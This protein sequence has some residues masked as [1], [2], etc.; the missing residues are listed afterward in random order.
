[1]S[2]F[3]GLP[4]PEMPYARPKQPRGTLDVSLDEGEGLRAVRQITSDSRKA[5]TDGGVGNQR[6]QSP[7]SSWNRSLIVRA[8]LGLGILRSSG[9]SWDR[10]VFNRPVRPGGLQFPG[11][12]LTVVPRSSESPRFSSKR[13]SGVLQL[14]KT[15]SQAVLGSWNSSCDR[16]S[17]PCV[18]L[19]SVY[20]R[21]AFVLV[22]EKRVTRYY[23]CPRL[24]GEYGVE[25]LNFGARLS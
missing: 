1:M 11:F 18:F 14:Y 22:N 8:V 3:P 17:C 13:S 10:S 15:V 25:T 19:G 12:G 7:E 2:V 6:D 16:L 23:F 4:V 21:S 24:L 20:D 5:I 9:W